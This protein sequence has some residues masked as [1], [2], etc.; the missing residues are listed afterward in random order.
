MA[1]RVGGINCH[2]LLFEGGF[3]SFTVKRTQKGFDVITTT[4]RQVAGQ[5]VASSRSYAECRCREFASHIAAALNAFEKPMK[6]NA[7]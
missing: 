1:Y 7:E 5:W 3:M 4:K 2:G 6:E